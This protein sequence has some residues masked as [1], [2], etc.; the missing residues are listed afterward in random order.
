MTTMSP[1]FICSLFLNLLI[2]FYFLS[3]IFFKE[4]PVPTKQFSCIAFRATHAPPV[5]KCVCHA[6]H[7]ADSATHMHYHR[8]GCNF[9]LFC[10]GDAWCERLLLLTLF[11]S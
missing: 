4:L 11:P 7:P 2:A 3:S 9:H 1:F 10:E 6:V 8:S 5:Q